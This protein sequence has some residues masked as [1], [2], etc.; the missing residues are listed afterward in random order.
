[1]SAVAITLDAIL[2]T[3]DWRRVRDNV[4]APDLLQEPA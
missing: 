3:L 2:V 1:V 4:A